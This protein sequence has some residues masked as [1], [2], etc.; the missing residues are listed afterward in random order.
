M[1]ENKKKVGS[2]KTALV[3]ALRNKFFLM[4]YKYSML[5]FVASVLIFIFSLFFAIF[6][7]RQPVHPQY[8]PLNED[9]TYF[10][11]E[12][13]SVCKPDAEV[14]KFT[15]NAIKKLYKY[16]Y[17]NYTDQIQDAAYYFTVSGWNEYLDNFSASS[18]L[19]AVKEN[20]WISTVDIGSVPSIIKQE[21]EG[22][23]CTWQVSA[24]ISVIYVGTR[25][26]K[27]SGIVYLKV[28][29]NSVINNSEGLG[30]KTLTF[31]PK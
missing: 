7:A 30:I 25:G 28:V 27:T 22:D 17:V 23:L 6:F 10:K 3:V 26:Q 31:V 1:S 11:L 12:S 24:P 4:H 9:G 14:Q 2:T 18:V 29:R 21:I 16:D 8:V 5:T 13:L 20:Q 19:S 15:L